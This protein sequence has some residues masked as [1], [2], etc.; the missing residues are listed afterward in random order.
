MNNDMT[1]KSYLDLTILFVKQNPVIW[2]LVLLSFAVSALLI[3]IVILICNKENWYD[4]IDS[5]KIHDGSIPRLG[6]I[7]FVIAFVLSS[8]IYMRIKRDAVSTMVPFI[9]SGFMIF[10][11]GIIDDF[12]NLKAIVKLTVQIIAALIIVATNHRFLNIG[13]Y[14]IPTWLSFLLTFGWIIGVVNAFNLIDGID[15]LCGG[16]SSLIIFTLS[17]IYARSAVHSAAE[18]LFIVAGLLGFLIYN[19]PKAKIFMGDGGSQFLGF[20]IAALPLYKTTENFEYNKFL[21]M[22]NLVSIP[23]LDCIAAIWRRLREHRGIMTPDRAHIHHKLMNIG[24]SSVQ[25]L[26]VLLVI[27]AFICCVCAIALYL[28]GAL[29]FTVLLLC[30]AV[31]VCFFVIV[32]YLNRRANIARKKNISSDS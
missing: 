18:C 25:V 28:K 11:F 7:G 29:A 26:I 3:P 24:L 9:I 30:Y 32:H 23:T 16:L 14:S 19:K 22:V 13:S 4:S 17:L 21:I 2:Y 5:R 1:L 10:I 8:F 20:M 27:Q 31:I 15:G 6:S 12:K